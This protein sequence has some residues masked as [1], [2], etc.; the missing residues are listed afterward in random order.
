MSEILND[1]NAYVK[2]LN[3]SS[4]DWNL[5]KLS[6]KDLDDDLAITDNSDIYT[7]DEMIDDAD[8]VEVVCEKNSS[9]NHCLMSANNFKHLTKD[10]KW[11]YV[12][13]DIWI[14]IEDYEQFEDAFELF[15]TFFLH[16][17]K[18]SYMIELQENLFFAELF[19]KK[20]ILM[21]GLMRIPF[22]FSELSPD[23]I[24]VDFFRMDQ[25][26]A[27]QI[28]DNIYFRY[29]IKFTFHRLPKN[30]ENLN[31]YDLNYFYQVAVSK[32][33]IEMFQ[34]KTSSDIIIQNKMFAPSAGRY[35]RNLCPIV[36]TFIIIRVNKCASLEELIV[37]D[38]ANRKIISF[39]A[40]LG[41]ILRYKSKNCFQSG[42]FYIIPLI[43][44][45][46]SIDDFKRYLRN[47]NNSKNKN[48]KN[49]LSNHVINKKMTQK[50]IF[51]FNVL[52]MVPDCFFIGFITSVSYCFFADVGDDSGL[53]IS[54][55]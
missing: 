41:E 35:S 32:R 29:R 6:K 36:K 15:C 52:D 45:V 38:E 43:P 44:D 21:N 34:N 14:E 49:E 5:I 51:R 27:I 20:P 18:F 9:T 50:F 55:N 26:F 17:D 13:K 7:I 4:F 25:W 19:G 33:H 23:I 22:V 24:P 1:Y 11:F 48:R 47:I 42:E 46:K 10:S 8:T 40:D 37:T 30:K 16:G 31:R 3:D 39:S 28:C 54:D 2:S 12:L 53:I